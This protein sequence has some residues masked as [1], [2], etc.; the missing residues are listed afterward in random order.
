MNKATRTL[1][2]IALA[3]AAMAA[4]ALAQVNEEY[5]QAPEISAQQ[6]INSPPLALGKLRGKV[7]L[8]DFWQYTCIG[9]IRT[10]PYLKLWNRL[11]GPLGLV[12]IGVHTP[13]FNFDQ[14]PQLVAE[15][16]KRFSI[17]FPVAVDSD[18]R[19]WRAFHNEG[20]PYGYL[21][22]KDRRVEYSR[23]GEGDNAAFERLI[24]QL[25]KQARPALDF[26]AARFIPRADQ[27]SNVKCKEPTPETYLGFV[28][29]DR[30]ANPEGYEQLASSSYRAVDKLPLDQFD[31]SGQ[32]SAMPESLNHADASAGGY[33]SLRLRYR[34][35]SVYLVA[36]S[37][38]GRPVPVVVTQ[39]G[40][41][42]G[43]E[44]RGADIQLL[45][46]GQSNL[47]IA[48]KRIYYL[49]ENRSFGEH[50]LDLRVSQRG[51][52]FYSFS[53]GGSCEPAFDHR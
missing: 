16:V 24:Q 2:P 37:D 7:L 46:D 1:A 17:E 9:C 39:D 33:D 29:A 51:G 53:F 8:I 12:V 42:I 13:E 44:S 14:D 36:G 52:S 30:L 43:P 40:T 15:A 47:P 4:L 34:A 48:G 45:A 23:C 11:Y 31:L 22:D 41:P 25:L 50:V 32:W 28:R 38:D 3:V 6:W 18:R 35:K 21:I 20:L 27:S 26:S 49:V 5:I 10:F 19:I